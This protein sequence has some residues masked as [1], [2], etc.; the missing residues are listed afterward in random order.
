MA[1]LRD[2]I[3][4]KFISFMH[5]TLYGL[6]VDP[7]ETLANAGLDQGQA[8][9]EA[10]FGPGFFTIP[11]AE[12]VGPEGEVYAFEINE[13]AYESVKKKLQ[14]KEV[15][16]VR[17]LL[18]DCADTELN[19]ESIDVAFFFGIFHA[20]SDPAPVLREMHRLLKPAGVLSIQ[21]GRVS[22]QRV[23]SL[24]GATGLFRVQSQQS[25]ILQF[26]KT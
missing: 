11:A 20:F 1:S 22:P 10:G 13:A 15:T 2:R 8:V 17:L 16:N 18:Q 3:E 7:H 6:F 26:A 14:E 5:S 23:A 19:D 25:K 12:I 21:A 9:L 4:F 24:V